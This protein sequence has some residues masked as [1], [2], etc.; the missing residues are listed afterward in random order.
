MR[1]LREHELAPVPVRQL[2]PIPARHDHGRGTSL[3]VA[4]APKYHLAGFGVEL[5]G[6]VQ[7]QK[8]LS[9]GQVVGYPRADGALD[10]YWRRFRPA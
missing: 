10:G 5:A 4:P 6:A 1:D 7:H 2:V 3:L 8:T 9:D